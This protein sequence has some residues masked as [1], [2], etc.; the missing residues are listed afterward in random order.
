MGE[1][2]A[3]KTL[4]AAVPLV[5]GCTRDPGHKGLHNDLLGIWWAS[6]DNRSVSRDGLT[7]DR[8]A[9]EAGDA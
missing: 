6:A 1:C 4:A 3:S 5:L 2:R 9:K 7:Y 8:P